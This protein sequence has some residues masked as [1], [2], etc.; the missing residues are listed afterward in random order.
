MPDQ[1]DII[2]PKS[3]ELGYKQPE[4]KKPSDEE[5]DGSDPVLAKRAQVKRWLK[6]IE[7]A[8]TKYKPD[9]D[10]MHENM[11]FVAGLQHNG[12]KT[13]RSNRDVVN[14]TLQ[15]VNH[16]V[17]QLYSRDPKV[18]VKRKPR[19]NYRLWDG[20][21]ETIQMAQAIMQFSQQAMMQGVMLPV[22]PDIQAMLADF[23]QGRMKEQVIDKVCQTIEKVCQYQMDSQTPRFK[24]Q[25][26][27]L[28]RRVCICGVG[29]IKPI[30]CR[31]Y[32]TELTQ[33]DTHSSVVERARSAK[34]IID[35]LSDGKLQEFDAEVERLKSLV[36]SFGM[37][38]LDYE[39]IR[40]REHT[41]ID[42]PQ[43]TSIIPDTNC[44]A[45]KGFVGARWVAE[46]FYYSL[47]FVNAFFETDIKVGGDLKLYDTKLGTGLGGTSQNSEDE[48]GKKVRLFQ[49]YDLDTKSTFMV[50]EGWKDYVVVPEVLTPTTRSFWNIVPVTFNDVEVE[51]GCKATIF[52]P[53]MVDL[54][55]TTQ[56]AWNIRRYRQNRHLAAN[57]PRYVY[58]DGAISKEDVERLTE[59]EDQEFVGLK[60][61]QP[62]TE[63]GKIVQP[64]QVAEVKKELYETQSLV[65][66][67]LMSTGSQEANIGPARPNVT[68]TVGTIAEQSRMS[69]T[70]SNIDDLD[71]ALTEVN[72][73]VAEMC[74]MEMSPQ[75]VQQIAG[76][77]AAW[78]TQN[79]QEFLSQI[80][81]EVLAASSGK[82]N[83][84]LAVA[85][86]ERIA[87]LI[88][89]A[90]GLPPQAQPTAQAI[91]RQSIKVLD[92][93]DI[94][95]IDFFPLPIPQGPPPGG[96]PPQ[97]GGPS[98]QPPKK[99]PPGPKQPLQPSMSGAA[100]PLVGHNQ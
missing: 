9:F 78:P 3:G 94:E 35:K 69:V 96:Q 37:D 11:D 88:M 97:Q 53:S 1:L 10:R 81:V 25:M 31:D 34:S 46:E 84:A 93:P 75:T 55:W 95:P 62:G 30:F 15:C 54:L 38:P 2:E 56:K 89:N 66:D 44:R 48:K 17:S 83:K 82:P 64:L 99:K 45:L 27:Q 13:I 76:I 42:F 63:P 24:V 65:E 19:M 59:S 49:V 6:K 33:S 14:L 90:A 73:I 68:A 98:S 32:E 100:V 80:E 5:D 74:I 92:A 72:Q 60:S 57:S 79:P 47:D 71:D 12:Q 20:K 7:H 18:S 26:K 29:F 91:I 36:Q 16:T 86:W 51:D 41:I 4:E 52:P 85:N 43:A 40:P 23:Q 70:T 61:L 28:V 58:P 21:I 87:P 50:C 67:T 39:V 77:G 22:P 8:A